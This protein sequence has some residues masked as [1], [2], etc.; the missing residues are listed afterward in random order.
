MGFLVWSQVSVLPSANT[1]FV[2]LMSSF[3]EENPSS[4]IYMYAHDLQQFLYNLCSLFTITWVQCYTVFKFSSLIQLLRGMDFDKEWKL[5]ILFINKA[6]QAQSLLSAVQLGIRR[7]S[8]NQYPTGTSCASLK[9]PGPSPAVRTHITMGRKQLSHLGSGL[10][11]VA[12]QSRPG[13]FRQQLVV[14]QMGYSGAPD[15][16]IFLQRRKRIMT[17]PRNQNL[18]PTTWYKCQ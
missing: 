11:L 13:V 8:K 17:S 9:E 10:L 6:F 3:L 14:K 7:Q 16:P 1:A 12:G 5:H 2:V 15:T 18:H 4:F